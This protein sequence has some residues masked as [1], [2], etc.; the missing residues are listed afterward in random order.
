MIEGYNKCKNELEEICN[1]LAAG[2]KTR[3]KTLLFEERKKII[4]SF[5]KLPKKK[6]EVIPGI[7]KKLEIENKTIS[8]PNEI[9][10][11][12]IDCLKSS[13]QRMR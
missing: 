11:E 1:N 6:K 13:L 10:N 7:I 12:Y 9:N 2:V 3:S 5:L 4:K 8:D